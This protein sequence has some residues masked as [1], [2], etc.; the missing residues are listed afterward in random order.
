MYVNHSQGVNGPTGPCGPP[1]LPLSDRGGEHVGDEEA[2]GYAALPFPQSDYALL[3]YF[4]RWIG[5]P[6]SWAADTLLATLLVVR[7]NRMLPL[8]VV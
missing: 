2:D 7:L 3:E 8:S 1:A 4:W 5:D 6:A